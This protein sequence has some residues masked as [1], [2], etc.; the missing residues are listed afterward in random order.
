M[1]VA[2]AT[3]LLALA[4][5]IPGVRAQSHCTPGSRASKCGNASASDAHTQRDPSFK[6]AGTL[7]IAESG[8]AKIWSYFTGPE[9]EG[10]KIKRTKGIIVDSLALHRLAG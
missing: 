4:D 5:F 9:R 6:D 7:K 10:G 2:K 3:V 8:E 1:R